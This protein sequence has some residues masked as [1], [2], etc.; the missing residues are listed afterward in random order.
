MCPL[1]LSN[2]LLFI[3]PGLQRPFTG[4]YASLIVFVSV[5]LQTL[6]Q[7]YYRSITR[8]RQH[9]NGRSSS[10]SGRLMVGPLE[11]FVRQSQQR[12]SQKHYDDADVIFSETVV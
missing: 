9:R 4:I 8:T 12:N 5:S 7:S 3:L 2:V 6:Y 10:S 11:N 1:L